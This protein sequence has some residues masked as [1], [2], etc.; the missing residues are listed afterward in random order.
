MAKVVVLN[1]VGL[2]PALLK[3]A[4]RLQA[5]GPPAPL[6]PPLPAVTCTSQATMLTGLAPRDHGIIGNGWY[7]RE[8]NEVLFWRQSSR[9]VHGTKVWEEFR[10]RTANLF[11]WFNMATTAAI[12]VTPRPAYF[13]DGR[14]MPDVYSDPPEIGRELQRRHGPFPLFRFWGPLAGIESTRWIA[15]AAIDVIRERDPDLALVYLPHLDY[16]LQRHGPGGA[17]EQV[18]AVDA[19]AARILDAAPG[20][21]ALVV[22]EYGITPVSGALHPNRALR[23]A[24]LLEVIDNPVGELLDPARSRAFAVCDHQ[25]AHVYTRDVGAARR[26]LDGMGEIVDLAAAGLDHP[27]AGDL[28]LVAPKDR[29]FA[30]PYWTDDARAPDFARTVD[31]H[32]KPGYDPCELFNAMSPLGTAWTLLRKKL[33]FR[34]LLETTPLDASIVKGS[35]GRLPDDPADGPLLLGNGD[36]PRAMAE[37]KAAILGALAR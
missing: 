28:V 27:R 17:A 29:W 11:W 8:L 25:I 22:S 18:R 34:A 9:L 10:G 3:H 32:R 6:T 20:R 16:D 26:A 7:F 30:Y 5:L 33:G 35:H 2:T 24:G 31:I 1:V 14:K 4:P 12:S 21:K 13:A 19:E 15:S 36:R 23:R 37:V